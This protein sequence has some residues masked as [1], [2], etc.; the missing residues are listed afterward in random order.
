MIKSNSLNLSDLRIR[1]YSM[2]KSEKN[3]TPYTSK[4]SEN[5]EYY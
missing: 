2:Q 3:L 1:S 5:Q 4:Y